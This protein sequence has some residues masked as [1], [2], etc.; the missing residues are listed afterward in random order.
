MVTTAFLIL[1][2]HTL[3]KPMVAWLIKLL[4]IAEV[5]ITKLPKESGLAHT[6]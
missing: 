4:A 5:K 6:A 1:G 3:G 2:R